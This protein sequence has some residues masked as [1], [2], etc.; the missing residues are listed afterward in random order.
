[1]RI[2][3]RQPSLPRANAV[4]I[5]VAEIV[6][7]KQP[8]DV[9]PGNRSRDRAI[10]P[11]CIKD[12]KWRLRSGSGCS[13]HMHLIARNRAEPV[14][15]L[16]LYRRQ[17][18]GRLDHRLYIEPSESGD[19]T[20]RAFKPLGIGNHAPQ[21]LISAAQTEHM[22]APPQMRRQIDIPALLP[23]M[24]HRRDCR[25][26]ARQDH[27]IGV[28]R[29]CLARRDHDHRHIL[30]RLQRIEIVKIGNMQKLGDRDADRAIF[31]ARVTR[32]E[33][34]TV[35]GRQRPRRRQIR[36]DPE[37]GQASPVG[38]HFN[39]AVEQ[40]DIAAEFVDHIALE[41]LLFVVGQDGVRARN[42]GDHAA[43]VDI[44]DQHHWRLRCQC[45]T[46]IGDIA[47]AEIDLGR[48]AGAFH[49]NNIGIV[50]QP[51]KGIAHARHQI[52]LDL[53]IGAGIVIADD[54]SL[55]DQLRAD[56]G[57]RFQQD[58][59]HVDGWRGF[60]GTR[61]Q[62]LRPADLKPFAGNGGIVRHVLR[63]ERPHPQS[64][65]YQHPAQPGHQHGFSDIRSCT[66]KHQ[67]ARCHIPNP[68]IRTRYRSGL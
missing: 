45:K 40:A 15:R 27:Q 1:M 43:P 61:L 53:L 41:Q 37:T 8:V 32:A 50:A 54:F 22:A 30:F 6:A 42:T 2:E 24:R 10:G 38:Q 21:H 39:G 25:L 26:G 11:A 23:E 31:S 29:Q 20:R 55:H 16:S 48:A 33:R 60:A 12:Q 51:V 68:T 65:L 35:F 66:L 17:G 18:L 19:V 59:V 47:G 46:H 56:I 67:G 14:L 58:R 28:S 4:Q 64:T 36:Y 62:C 49:Q 57:L 13:A 7:G 44:A 52:R 5:P 34:Q 3:V 63:L 9:T